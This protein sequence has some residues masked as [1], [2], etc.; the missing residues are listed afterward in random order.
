[1][2]QAVP[3]FQEALAFVDQI[4]DPWSTLW[5]LTVR[6]QWM[7]YI[8]DPSAVTLARVALARESK[9]PEP[10]GR[11][12][13]LWFL[14]DALLSQGQLDEARDALAEAS[15]SLPLARER[16]LPRRTL[17]IVAFKSGDFEAAEA[18]L[19]D[20]LELLHQYSDLRGYAVG[21]QEL[22][23]VAAARA[24]W[25]RGARM[26]GASAML[27]DHIS[28]QPVPVWDIGPREAAEACQNALGDDAFAQLFA[29]GQSMS[30][31]RAV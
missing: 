15:D 1:V 29:E 30:I 2:E 19:R 9:D 18:H 7:T 4:D 14:G 27:F 13:W 8:G 6:I 17:G 25:E 24:E 10:F 16:A 11:P 5:C 31:D 23:C 21:V 20:S 3:I 22:A 12:F 26:L 28:T